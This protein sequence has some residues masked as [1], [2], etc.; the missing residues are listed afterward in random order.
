M[1]GKLKITKM[2]Y[3]HVSIEKDVEGSTFNLFILMEWQKS[4]QIV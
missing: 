4:F 2:F 1:A 3:K